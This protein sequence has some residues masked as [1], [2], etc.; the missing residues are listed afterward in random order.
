MPG[1]KQPGPVRGRVEGDRSGSHRTDS[2]LAAS[3]ET[4]DRV[5]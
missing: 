4:I 5:V 2:A 1:R 3:C